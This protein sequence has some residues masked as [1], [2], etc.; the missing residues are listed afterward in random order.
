MN[1]LALSRKIYLTSKYLNSFYIGTLF[2]LIIPTK[3]NHEVQVDT[4]LYK[5]NKIYIYY[6]ELFHYNCV[7]YTYVM[8]YYLLIPIN[9]LIFTNICQE[10][11]YS[12]FGT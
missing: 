4:R 2:Q 12:Y 10:K 7:T 6:I 1:R 5:Y 3:L 11:K 9:S 8:K